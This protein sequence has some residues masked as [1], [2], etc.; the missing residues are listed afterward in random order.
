M[1]AQPKAAVARELEVVADVTEG[2]PCL[3]LFLVREKL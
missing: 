2:A 1:G 3:L